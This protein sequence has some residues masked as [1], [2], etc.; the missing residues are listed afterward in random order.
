MIGIISFFYLSGQTNPFIVNLFYI[1]SLLAVYAFFSSILFIVREI[2]RENDELVK[3]VAF[4]SMAM[5]F[6]IIIILHVVQM[7]VRITYFNKTGNDINLIVTSGYSIESLGDKGSHLEAFGFDLAIYSI[8][9]FVNRLRYAG[10]TEWIKH[11]HA[12]K[13]EE[14]IEESSKIENEETEDGFV[15]F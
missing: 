3:K 15:K 12:V 6:V 14:P 10:R 7:M 13:S 2:R 8:C 4:D 9:L 5:A 11:R 1:L